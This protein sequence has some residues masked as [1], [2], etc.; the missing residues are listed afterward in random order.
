MKSGTLQLNYQAYLLR[1]WQERSGL[2]GS[3]PIWRFSLEDTQTG[4]RH[5]FGSLKA[6]T[7]YL[8]ATLIG[9]V[10]ASADT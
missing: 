9:D 1:C 7:A 5:G 6:L 8:E 2:P 3:A 4:E 10:D